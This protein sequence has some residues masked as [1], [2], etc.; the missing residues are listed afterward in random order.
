MEKIENKETRS[1]VCNF[2]SKCL[3]VK[4][5]EYS[6]YNTYK[7]EQEWII[8]H[9]QS[10][11][12]GTGWTHFCSKECLIQYISDKEMG[13]YDRFHMSAKQLNTLLTT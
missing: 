1:I 8:L 4:S 12:H 7:D 5:E 13:M 2:C 10:G 9:F 6:P 11:D 3:E